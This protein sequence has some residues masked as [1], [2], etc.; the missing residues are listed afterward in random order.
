MFDPEKI[1]VKVVNC[2]GETHKTETV[3]NFL[4]FNVSHCFI[5][6]I[7]H[8]GPKISHTLLQD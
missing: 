5:H 4:R 3:Q 8:K 2:L 7:F 1:R 6:A